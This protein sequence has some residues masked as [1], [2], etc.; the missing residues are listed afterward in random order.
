M[1]GKSFLI[2]VVA[3]FHCFAERIK[4]IY[5]T[6]LEIISIYIVLSA[7]FFLNNIFW[8][9]WL[10]NVIPLFLATLIAYLYTFNIRYFDILAFINFLIFLDLFWVTA[11]LFVLFVVKPSNITAVFGGITFLVSFISIV[12]F[13]LC[14]DAYPRLKKIVDKSTFIEV[15]PLVIILLI[16]WILRFLYLPRY[17]TPDEYYY[18]I[19][20]DQIIQGMNPAPFYV[21]LG[22]LAQVLQGRYLWILHIALGKVIGN[23]FFAVDLAITFVYS[24]TL[25]VLKRMNIN[26]S[27][28]T[29][30]AVIST[31]LPNI[32]SLAFLIL[33][34]LFLHALFFICIIQFSV[35]TEVIMDKSD[36]KKSEHIA[37][38]LGIPS[39]IILLM[40]IKLNEGIIIVF[41]LLVILNMRFARKKSRAIN[42]LYCGLLSFL[43]AYEVFIDVPVTIL[44]YI[45]KTEPPALLEDLRIIKPAGFLVSFIVKT[46]FAKTFSEITLS[47]ILEEFL[48]VLSINRLSVIVFSFALG[49]VFV[50]FRDSSI[51]DTILTRNLRDSFIFYMGIAI[52]YFAL[53]EYPSLGWDEARN[54]LILDIL[55]LVLSVLFLKYMQRYLATQDFGKSVMGLVIAFSALLIIIYIS[56]ISPETR[57]ALIMLSIF[58]IRKDMYL[59][60]NLGLSIMSILLLLVVVAYLLSGVHDRISIHTHLWKKI[61]KIIALIFIIYLFLYV[62][63]VAYIYRAENVIVLDDY[64]LDDISNFIEKS[65]VE[66]V[67]TNVYAALK[68]NHS[69]IVIS[70]P[71]TYKEL[72]SIL[73]MKISILVVHDNRPIPTWI[74]YVYGSVDLINESLIELISNRR[75]VIT[76]RVTPNTTAYLITG[77]PLKKSSKV[78]L[79]EK[80]FVYVEQFLARLRIALFAKV[81]T[82]VK[83]I[84]SSA[85]CSRFFVFN[86]TYGENIF[87]IDFPR[88]IYVGTRARFYGPYFQRQS[89]IAIFDGDDN[90]V[91]SATIN[92]NTGSSGNIIKI[93]LLL[94]IFILT[95]IFYLVSHF[96]LQQFRT[97]EQ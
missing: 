31:F 72:L 42:I 56:N 95:L 82:K 63:Y 52:V 19:L 89:I 37:Y 73:E 81:A 83:I 86:C 77:L 66:F 44:R 29:C 14:V 5:T 24:G 10:L 96:I 41:L 36:F 69:K 50:S 91:F 1:L 35:L 59:V 33:P 23:V 22:N 28:A 60:M 51:I 58:G 80:A 27:L 71:L 26:N 85:C 76:Y 70:Y 34:D 61:G 97:D 2:R 65:P 7:I 49:S 25:Y 84:V 62:I 79:I 11:F 75:N 21:V 87:T 6:L 15:F 17:P 55:A 68:N 20:A 54:S 38:L 40:M 53:L 3:S 64:D 8:K 45:L 46:P 18:L 92:M 57:Y 13:L 43:I 32:H 39:Y 88:I 16:Y 74:N 4:R 30:L 93:Y 78:E 94:I 48:W 90:I 67:V 9:I 47:D 12:V